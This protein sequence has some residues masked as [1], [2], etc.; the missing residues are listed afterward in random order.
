MPTSHCAEKHG[1]IVGEGD[2]CVVASSSHAPGVCFI[3]D[4]L[5]INA[6]TAALNSQ[7][8]GHIRK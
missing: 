6:V 7:W 5:S 3:D 2:E 4:V 1:T 8:E